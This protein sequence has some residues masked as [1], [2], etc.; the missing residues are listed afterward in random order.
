MKILNV[1]CAVFF[2]FLF[3]G[4]GALVAM[5]NKEEKAQRTASE[6][7]HEAFSLENFL[8]KPEI[9]LYEGKTL[10]VV[11]DD[12]LKDQLED[13]QISKNNKIT[14]MFLKRFKAIDPTKVS[15]D[16]VGFYF[17]LGNERIYLK[18]FL[19]ENAY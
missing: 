16:V 7:Y 15:S 1:S 12:K 13:E 3:G 4:S 6:F 8:K 19:G 5:E 14:C 11:L 10:R 9:K 18:P 17:S 2:G